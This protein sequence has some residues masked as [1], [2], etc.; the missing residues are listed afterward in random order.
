[1]EKRYTMLILIKRKMESHFQF[2]NL[3]QNYSNQDSMIAQDGHL[4]QQNRIKS[5][6]KTLKHLWSIDFLQRGAKTV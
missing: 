1:M 3:L 4:E 6:E 2:Q 5:L